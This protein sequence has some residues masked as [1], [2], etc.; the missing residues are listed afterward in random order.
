MITPS[1]VYNT[2]GDDSV[3]SSFHLE[4][5]K[6]LYYPAQ[7]WS[8]KNHIRL[9]K[10]LKKLLEEGYDLKLVF[11]GSDQGNLKYVQR[12]TKELGLENNVIF[13]GF[14]PRNQIISLYKNAYALAYASYF[15][16]DN[17]PPLEA[18]A[19]GCPVICSEYKGAHEQLGD[20]ALF[21]NQ[22]TGENFKENIDKLKDEKCRAEIIQKGRTLA[23]NC[24]TENYVKKM[25]E[26]IDEF[27]Y[28][29]EC[30]GSV[31]SE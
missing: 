7:F 13:A 21:F 4:K 29:R 2:Q 1:D 5:N 28:I 27:S 18:M 3:L 8:H 30:W 12:R 11:S 17:I 15:G 31:Y 14:L 22:T 10:E 19:L 26:I 16:P 23:K 6:F 20:C 25:F 9:L 24:S